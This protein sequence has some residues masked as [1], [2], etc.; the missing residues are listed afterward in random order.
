MIRS[1]KLQ[2]FLKFNLHK[3]FAK[4]CTFHYLCYDYHLVT[5][6]K[7][8]IICLMSKRFHRVP[9][10]DSEKLIYF[11]SCMIEK[12]SICSKCFLCNLMSIIC[13]IITKYNYVLNHKNQ[14]CISFSFSSMYIYS[15]I[16]VSKWNKCLFL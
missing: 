16:L 7:R 12:K 15:F 9:W 13:R 10:K 14:F 2:S 6:H 11:L 3:G 8:R 5:S 1:T 4:Y